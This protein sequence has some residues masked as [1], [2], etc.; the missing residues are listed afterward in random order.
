MAAQTALIFDNG[1][2]HHLLR[3]AVCEWQEIMRV[4]RLRVLVLML[5]LNK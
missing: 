4:D 3:A 5:A 2:N 1:T